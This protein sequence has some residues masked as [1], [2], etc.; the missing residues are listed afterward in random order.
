MN[1]KFISIEDEIY[2]CDCIIAVSFCDRFIRILL[3]TDNIIYKRIEYHQFLWSSFNCFMQGLYRSDLGFG[4]L[5]N[6][7]DRLK[8]TYDVD[9]LHKN[10]CEEAMNNA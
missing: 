7:E 10:A 5:F 6:F 2:N 3:K 9:L 8:E 4:S 1:K